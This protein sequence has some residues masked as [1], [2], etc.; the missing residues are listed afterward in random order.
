MKGSIVGQCRLCLN[1]TKLQH[2][3][4]IS[5]AAYK[6]LRGDGK[7]PHP[8]LSDGRTVIQTAMQVRAHLLCYDCE[9]RFANNGEN[10]FFRYCYQ[11]SRRFPLLT[12]LRRLKPVSEEDRFAIHAVPQSQNLIVEQIAYFGISLFWKSAS[13]VWR[14]R[15]GFVH[16][17]DLGMKYQEHL[18][19]FL[20]GNTV[21][22]EHAVLAVDVSDERNRLI[23]TFGT[24]VS[25]K[26]PTNHFHWVS[27]LG[28]RFNLFVGARTPKAL[29]PL[30]VL[31]NGQKYLT[32]AKQEE[33]MLTKV[34]REN[35]NSIAR[36]STK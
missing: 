2:S 9:Q 27:I 20:L 28:I 30:C 3:H 32:V 10:T 14:E 4:F 34:Y 26:H 1:V 16:S 25:I 35:L 33:A 29:K 15:N 13:H 36:L 12:L 23:G 24:P 19:T 17:I 11:N 31:T 5:Q 22:P 8:L 6:R 18:R 21:F 7:N